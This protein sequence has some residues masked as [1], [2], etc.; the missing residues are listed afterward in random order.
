MVIDE[1][2]QQLET[3]H[4][5]LEVATKLCNLTQFTIHMNAFTIAGV[6]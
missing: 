5:R 3:E 2:G 1:L 4:T 6:L